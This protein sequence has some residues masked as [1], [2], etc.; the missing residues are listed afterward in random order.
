MRFRDLTRPLPLLAC[1]TPNSSAAVVAY[2]VAY[3]LALLP[4]EL[5]LLYYTH[6]EIFRSP[7]LLLG[8]LS[9]RP[10]TS[11]LSTVLSICEFFQD[12]QFELENQ[13]FSN[14]MFA[15]LDSASGLN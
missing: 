14:Y 10:D 12:L 7:P 8:R 5:G 1:T 3:G 2:P 4:S 11:R 9:L 15:N 6:R 13:F